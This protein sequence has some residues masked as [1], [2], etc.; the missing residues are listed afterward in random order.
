L[1]RLGSDYVVRLARIDW[2][3]DGIDKECQ[4]L[5]KLS[6]FFCKYR[7]FE[8]VF[9]GHSEPF[10]PCPWIIAKWNEGENPA[11][12]QKNE[13]TLLAQD[14]A[15]F[16]NV[17]H[18]IK[19]KNGPVSRRGV[20]LKQLDAETRNAINQL[21]GEID[22]PLIIDLWKQLTNIPVWQKAPVW[23]HGD[24]LPGNILIQDN[25][26]SAVI[27]FSDV[28]MGDP[29]CD[30]VIAWSLFN[31]PSREIF[32]QHL[33]NIDHDTWE[34]GRGWALVIALI[35]LPYYKY[36]NP[37]LARLARQIIKNILSD[38]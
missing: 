19:L 25:R 1:F 35:M 2:T 22:I 5:P 9:K 24:F 28:G 36:S 18:G 15:D 12:E 34:R 11:F 31:H 30:F 21:E 10:Y 38:F 6:Q 4:W 3:V 37:A 8:P 20:P 33:E 29:A 7:I 23:V 27:D 14:L 17:L 16:L 32:K 13:Y 26:L